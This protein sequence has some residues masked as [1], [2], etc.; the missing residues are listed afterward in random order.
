MKNPDEHPHFLGKGI[1]SRAFS[2]PVGNN[3]YVIR[4]KIGENRS[5]SGINSYIAP[6]ILG[7]GIPH[8]EQIIAASYEKGVTVS[9]LIPGKQI[10]E[11]TLDDSSEISDVQLETLVDT[12]VVA[13]KRGI[14]IDPKSSNLLYD[15]ESGFGIVDYNISRGDIPISENLRL[16][17]LVG[18]I[19]RTLASIGGKDLKQSNRTSESYPRTL[20]TILEGGLELERRFQKILKTKTSWRG[21][22]HST[23]M[24]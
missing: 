20:V 13:S 9:E 19:A 11:L 5:P 18:N 7:K 17:R 1:N 12:L 10:E 21:F 8:L 24:Y 16:G 3:I 6:L 22:I 2:V 4:V 23:V 14:E 15:H